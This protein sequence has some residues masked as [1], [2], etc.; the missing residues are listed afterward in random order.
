MNSEQLSK[1]K[2]LKELLDRGVLTKEEVEQEKKRILQS[3]ES[4][5]SKQSS[6]NIAPLN[7]I[8]PKDNKDAAK[9]SIVWICSAVLLLLVCIVLLLSKRNETAREF[10]TESTQVE[11]LFSGSNSKTKD[12]HEWVDLGLPSGLKWA[13]CNLGALSPEEY[14]SYFAWGET[15][16]KNEFTFENNRY[17]LSSDDDYTYDFSKYSRMVGGDNKSRLDMSDD[18][19]RL[20][21]GGKW[22]IPTEK[23]V[24][25]LMQYCTWKRTTLG[26]VWGMKIIGPNGKS[27]FLPAAGYRSDRKLY[28]SESDGLYMS[29]SLADEDCFIYA[30]YF[31]G[32]EASLTDGI[33]RSDGLSIRPVCD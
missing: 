16:T 25:E 4:P 24:N 20:N 6:G 28:R 2:E 10:G 31:R 26:D 29:S 12:S 13:T 5:S 18:A 8:Q 21:W 15:E 1:L 11:D 22:R 32:A 9:K 19:A 17:C 23:E 14:G 27:I 7:K 33:A 3:T 30:L